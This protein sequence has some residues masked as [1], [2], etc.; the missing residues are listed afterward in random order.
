M[1]E[2]IAKEWVEAL[3]S[4]EFV[5]G[6]K[7]RMKDETGGYCCLGVL[8]CLHNCTMTPDLKD[9]DE[10]MPTYECRRWA[11]MEAAS[12][13]LLANMNDGSETFKRRHSFAEIADYIEKNWRDL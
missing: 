1:N 8:S 4:G 3:R 6:D 13:S 11:E 5:Q 12:A 10:E 2:K 9:G 7:Q